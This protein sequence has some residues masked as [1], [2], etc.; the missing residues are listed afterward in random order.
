MATINAVIQML[1][2]PPK[3]PINQLISNVKMTS[4]ARVA[5]LFVIERAGEGEMRLS[6]QEAIKMLLRNGDDAYGFPPYQHLESFL[7]LTD[8]VDLR[9]VERRL[10][11]Q[12]LRGQP[13][14]LLRSTKLDWAQRIPT[15]I[16]RIV[17][18]R[19]P[20][21]RPSLTVGR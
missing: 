10:V 15:F 16:N 19:F 7:R 18:P 6:N 13:A 20:A 3:Y 9:D 14:L 11:T 4:E 1:V 8:G 21:W 5:G 12:A 2:P 17:R